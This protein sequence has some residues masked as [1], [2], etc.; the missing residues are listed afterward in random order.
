MGILLKALDRSI[1]FGVGALKDIRSVS[2]DPADKGFS[3]S[4]LN[5]LQ[6]RQLGVGSDLCLGQTF[7]LL[8]VP[9]FEAL[10]HS[11]VQW[12]SFDLPLNLIMVSHGLSC[13][14]IWAGGTSCPS[15]LIVMLWH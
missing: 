9:R 5:P 8:Y 11:V 6:I 1:D 3:A 13:W 12:G 2:T 14:S 15:H 4:T 7:Q 10:R